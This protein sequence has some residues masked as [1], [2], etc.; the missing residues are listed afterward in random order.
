MSIEKAA[1]T[2]KN[3]GV[4]AFPTDTVYGIGV[5]PFQP[6]AI[7]KLYTI[8]GRPRDK[9]IPILVGS[10][11]D[12]E[13]VAQ[14]LP[15]IF[16]QLIKQFWPGALT[17]IVEAKGLPTQITAG[18]K[19]VGLRMPN[20]PIALKMLRCFAGPIATTS[21]NKSNKAPTTSK[22]QIEQ[23]L[24]SLVD[25][26]IDGGETN[27]GTSSTVIDLIETPPKVLRQGEIFIEVETPQ[28]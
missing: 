3:G 4:V 5:D 6:E 18:G 13:N 19:T 26:I 21:A 17:L 12:V 8:K 10:H 28:S 20:H 23:E 1:D 9:P 14:N 15:K 25:L 24:G 2:L 27:T 16:F 11:Q 22:L 7:E